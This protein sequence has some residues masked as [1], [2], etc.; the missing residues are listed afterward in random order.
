MAA[1]AARASRTFRVFVSS[2]FEDF[3]AERNALQQHVFPRLAE[4]CASRN[5]RFQAIDLRWGVGEE[6]GL[7]QRA[8]PICL[9][10]IERCQRVTPRPNFIVLLGDRYGWCPLPAR[11]DAVEFEAI[12]G[13]VSEEDARLLVWNADQ[14]ADAGGWYRCDE[15]GDPREYVLRPRRVSIP[16][17]ATAE[18]RKAAQDVEY[19]EWSAIEARLRAILLRAV[20]S[21]GWGRDD[22]AVAKY[23]A[24]ATEQ[25]IVRGVLESDNAAEHVFGFFRSI[26]SL[27]VEE[28]AKG[29]CDLAETPDGLVV[30]ADAKTRLGEL[31]ARLKD[32]LGNHVLASYEATWNG[33]EITTEHLGDLPGTLDQCLALLGRSDA[34]HTL[35]VDVWRSL[36]GVIKSQLEQP[37]TEEA[38]ERE[39][40]SHV[41]F[42][43]ARCSNFVGRD[44]IRTEIAGYLA[45]SEPQLLALIG[46]GGSGKSALMAK[47]L[48][49]A[50]DAGPGAVRVVRFI[51]ATPASSDGRS[52]LNSVC[53]QMAR[54]Y[55]GDESA[56]PAGYD[57][58][59]A[60]FGKQLEHATR[61]RPLIV[62][63]DALDQ[64]AVT[65]PARGL[66]W[67][68]AHLPDHVRLVVSTLP[69]DC[70]G[71]LGAKHPEPRFLGLDK[72][73]RQEGETALGLWLGK[74]RRKLQDQQLR[75]VLDKFEPEGRPLYLKLAF[76][77]ARLWRSFSE[78][79]ETR[80][81]AGIT[82]L[83]SGDLLG[84]L[85]APENHGQKLVAHALGCLA[86]S[87]HGMA[88]DELLA[89]L[90]A[91]KDVT[92]D[93]HDRSPRSPDVSQLPVVVWSRLFFDLEPYLSERAADSTTLLAFY[94]RVLRE[95][96]AEQYLAAADGPARHASLAD[97]FRAK[98]DPSHDRAW[99]GNSVRG[100]SELPFHLAEPADWR[101]STR[102]SPTSVSWSTRQPMSARS[103]TLARMAA[104]PRPTQAS[105]PSKTT[106]R[107]P[108]RS[109]AAAR[110]RA[111]A[112]R[113]S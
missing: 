4:L 86:A 88:E 26:D 62:F 94:H 91:D 81:H 53:R 29:F 18:Q 58:L 37:E 76:E 42:G 8:I 15:N 83:I 107:S 57:E 27:P 30:D 45:G 61:E 47:A 3:K 110:R 101:T 23:V 22:Q 106:T 16:E 40:I 100:L 36:A 11:I 20:E 77:E 46:E 75:E 55:G 14:E 38:I 85:A 54:A 109:W 70:E 51:G 13:K 48:A 84:R 52:L 10:E 95:A 39:I 43:A 25:E 108:W 59:A 89:V 32:L 7:D 12:L 82:E 66:S 64:L 65:D 87:R 74:A 5:A 72:L 80:L 99:T 9:T 6:A 69:G 103:S 93:F 104:R 111:A 73:T 17:G 21:L 1:E 97:Y 33:T 90:S 79:D 92:T 28:S 98:A 71:A 105:S 56:I 112:G 96:A 41:K 35:C 67:L 34:P 68:P 113:S 31:K 24:S 63:L 102:P 2:T 78:P 44:A 50:G 49:E 19:K 60:E